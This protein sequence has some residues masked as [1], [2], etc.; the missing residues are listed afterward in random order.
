MSWAK[1]GLQ[2]LL[3]KTGIKTKS[4]CLKTVSSFFHSHIVDTKPITNISWGMFNTFVETLIFSGVKLLKQTITLIK[5]HSCATYLLFSSYVTKHFSTFWEFYSL[6]LS[7]LQNL[8]P[9]NHPSEVLHGAQIAQNLF[10]WE[11]IIV[12]NLYFK[13]QHT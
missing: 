4:V 11:G 5:M 10:L 13:H 2:L 1:L 9:N 12:P 6:P 8:H 3:R 7:R